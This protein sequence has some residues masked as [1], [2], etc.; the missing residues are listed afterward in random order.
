MGARELTWYSED[1]YAIETIN[2]YATAKANGYDTPKLHQ[3]FEHF[4]YEFRRAIR[5]EYFEFVG[6][7]FADAYYIFHMVKKPRL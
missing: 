2:A 4:L 6:S 5:E 1:P 3:A 7:T